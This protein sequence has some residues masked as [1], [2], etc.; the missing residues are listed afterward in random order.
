MVR[1]QLR[2]S[3]PKTEKRKGKDVAA[4]AEVPLSSLGHGKATPETPNKITNFYTV[5]KVNQHGQETNLK[6]F[7]VSKVLIDGGSVFNMIS[8]HLTWQMGLK[9]IDPN[10]VLIRTAAST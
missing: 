8:L 5:A 10:E 6:I 9:L 2:P 3:G 1:E 7:Q 4:I